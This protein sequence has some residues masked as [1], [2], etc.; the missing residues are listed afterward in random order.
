MSSRE[1]SFPLKGVFATAVEQFDRAVRT[2]K[3]ETAP[4]ERLNRA[5]QLIDSM[6]G[7]I[8][9]SNLIGTSPAPKQLERGISVLRS[10]AP[11]PCT[12]EPGAAR[13]PEK[14]MDELFAVQQ[15]L[16]AMRAGPEWDWACID[17]EPENGSWTMPTGA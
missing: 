11:A 7:L 8:E 13:S 2:R 6:I 3:I 5:I 9:Y 14:L 16:L 15:Q 1:E 17:D 12:I 4:R 10:V